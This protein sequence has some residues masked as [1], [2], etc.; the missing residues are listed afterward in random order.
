MRALAE[1]ANNPA[2]YGGYGSADL[3]SFLFHLGDIVYKPDPEND[4]LVIA[5]QHKLYNA[6]FYKQYA[7][8]K[9]EIFSIP[10]NHDS[11]C[12]KDADQSAIDHY[13]I[14]F[15]DSKRQISPDNVKERK[16]K[17][18]IQPYPYWMLETPIAYIVG[19]DTNDLNGGLLDDPEQNEE[20]QFTWLLRRF[21]EIK[22]AENGK[23][24]VVAVHYPPYSGA[25][26][27]TQRGDP[28]LGPT[29][30]RNS[31]ARLSR[32]LAVT[33]QQTYQQTGLYPDLVI[34]AHA[35]LYQRIS[36]TYTGGFQIPHLICGASGH[37]PIENIAE[38]TDSSIGKKPIPPFPTV[39]PRG[40]ILPPGDSAVVE[41]FNDTDFGFLRITIDLIQNVIAGE[42]FTVDVKGNASPKRFDSFELDLQS[43]KLR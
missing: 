5:D 9:P 2:I 18:M 15:C 39:L 20:P 23:R 14:N 24:L 4:S 32:P 42:F 36:Y 7:A 29:P 6:Q 28:N 25:A 13:L 8:Y 17:T 35:H 19:L 34:S 38:Q 27:F 21:Q 41:S 40:L 30:R 12:S 33:L 43:H 22:K 1:Q 11:K 31:I 26:N 10:G 37:W 3:P 16:R